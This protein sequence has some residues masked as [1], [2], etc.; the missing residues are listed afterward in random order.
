MPIWF[1]SGTLTFPVAS[2]PDLPPVIMIGPG[3][4]CAPF[5]AYIQ[6][7]VAS[8]QHENVVMV[9][10]CRNCDKDF[11]FKEEWE[12]L[13]AEK[14]LI[15]HCA[16]SRDQDDKVYVQHVMRQHADSFWDLIGNKKAMVFFAGNA[17]RVPIDIYEAL[18]FI[19]EKGLGCST[20]DVEE[21]MKKD[22]EKRYQTETWA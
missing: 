11:F 20:Q 2:S 21:Y 22:L 15:L 10:G 5:R 1:K 13:V 19:C 8:G 6:E 18:T 7:R 16:F 4:G 17:K 9:F 3:T 14:K 12:A